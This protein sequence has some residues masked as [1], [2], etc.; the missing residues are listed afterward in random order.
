MAEAVVERP[1]K[2]EDDPPRATWRLLV[3]P[4]Y[5]PFFYGKLL[6]SAG[7]WVN[8]VVSAIVAYQLSGSAFVVGLV[9][10]AQFLPQTLLAPLSGAMA[11]RGDRRRQLITGRIVAATGSTVVGTWILLVGVENLPNVLPVL[12]AALVVGFGFTIGHPA[13]HSLVPSLVKPSELPAAIA[14]GN[15]PFTIARAGGPAVGALVATSLGPGYG[16]LLAAAGNL[17]FAALLV[18]MKVGRRVG[19]RKPRDASSTV[20]AGFAYVRRDPSI[21]LLLLGVAAISFGTDPVLTLSPSIAAA[22]GSGSHAVG[23]LVS[24]FG[25]GAGLGL[26]LTRPVQGAIGIARACAAGLVVL[27]AGNLSAAA[28]WSLPTAAGSFLV[29]GI[30]MSIA[31]SSFSTQLQLRLTDGFRGRVMALWIVAFQGTRPLAA[32]MSGSLA[33]VSSATVSLVTVAGLITVAAFFCRPSRIG[34]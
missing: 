28:S 11:D 9:S 7:M 2:G 26:T 24:S 3:D 14:L 18:P 15:A 10:V 1:G 23:M 32:L 30:G 12:V 8:N 17:A 31:L 4:Q 22:S 34:G 16:F 20:R 25:V 29:A 6:S 21:L 19:P 5:G 33:D 13:M 27:A